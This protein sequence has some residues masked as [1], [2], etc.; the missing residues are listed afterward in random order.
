MKTSGSPRVSPPLWAPRSTTCE[1]GN[2]DGHDRQGG[3][4]AGQ[5]P[6]QADVEQRLLGG[7]GRADL[8]E[9]AEG[10]DQGGGRDEVGQG[11]LDAM[12]AAGEKMAQFMDQQ[13]AQQG[14][15]VGEAPQPGGRMVPEKSPEA[16][17]GGQGHRMEAD[18]ILNA[19]DQGENQGQQEQQP[20]DG[21]FP[22]AACIKSAKFIVGFFQN[23][24]CRVE[25]GDENKKGGKALFN[26]GI[27]GANRGALGFV[28]VALAFHAHA[29]V[30][31]VILVAL[32][33]RLDGQTA[34]QAP[35]LIQVSLIVNAIQSSL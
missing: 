6:G 20:G 23:S 26:A 16:A 33:D 2:A 19:D 9:G 5:R 31:H 3:Q 7:E 27:G 13:D 35:Q 11:G 1:K 15:G 12:A 34:S 18:M 32:G 4:E 24:P 14:A 30:D 8:D 21:V 17:A 10:A 25:A 22:E 29:G 28:E